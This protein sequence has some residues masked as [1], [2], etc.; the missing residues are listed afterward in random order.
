MDT[1]IQ[2]R[3]KE[4]LQ[5]Y[6]V[7]HGQTKWNVE[8]KFQGW[9]GAPLTTKGL[10]QVRRLKRRL[11]GIPF[12]RAYIS[13]L[14]R[15]HRTAQILLENRG[16]P[17][18][19]EPRLKEIHF[20]AWEG[21]TLQ[22]IAKEDLQQASNFQEAPDKYEPSTGEN[23]HEVQTRVISAV[24]DILSHHQDVPLLIVSHGC[25]SKL[26]LSHFE[27][28]PLRNLWHPPKLKAA[29][30]SLVEV[31]DGKTNIVLFGDTSH[32]MD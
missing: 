4:M 25:A 31:K 22:E 7:R 30:L 12:K 32:L 13:P 29:S 15:T 16:T 8:G 20:G 27:G 6:I 11:R 14:P 10:H 24:E 26:M 5:L 3:T 28:R 23:F 18:I 21:K 1:D 17:Q 19:L 9:S 2:D